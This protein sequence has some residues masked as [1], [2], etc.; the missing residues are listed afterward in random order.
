MILCVRKLL[1]KET[2]TEIKQVFTFKLTCMKE[3]TSYQK[4]QNNVKK[5]P[6]LQNTLAFVSTDYL[7]VCL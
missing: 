7:R 4:Q 6:I 1:N 2:L 5:M 3:A